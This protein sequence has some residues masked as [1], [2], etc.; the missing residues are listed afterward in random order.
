MAFKSPEPDI[1]IPRPSAVSLVCVPGSDIFFPSKS[2][3][4]LLQELVQNF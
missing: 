2:L 3:R 4:A 1:V